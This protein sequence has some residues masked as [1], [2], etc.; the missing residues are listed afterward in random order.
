MLRVGVARAE[1]DMAF[2]DGTLLRAGEPV[3]VLHLWNEHIATI[4]TAG[5]DLR[6]AM[7]LRDSMA[8]SLRQLAE[9]AKSDPRLS[10]TKAFGG[11]AV[12]VSRHGTAQVARLAARYGFDWIRTGPPRTPARRVHD[13]FE[14]F[15][16]LGL[17]WAFNPAGLRGKRFIRPREPF[18]ITRATLLAKYGPEP[19]PAT[20]PVK[21]IAVA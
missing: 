15:L 9:A 10:Q 8:F 19:R 17:Q 6:W 1:A 18:W 7:E 14:N 12:F 3:G 2:S 21:L 16:V 13:F 11:T 20:E 4:P 5:P